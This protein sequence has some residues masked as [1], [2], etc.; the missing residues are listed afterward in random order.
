LRQAHACLGLADRRDAGQIIEQGS[1]ERIF[2][3][4]ET[5]YAKELI[6]ASQA[7]ASPP[8]AHSVQAGRPRGDR[9]DQPRLV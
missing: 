2:T 4:R 8:D 7:A 9:R 5:D 3:A 1:A 6:D